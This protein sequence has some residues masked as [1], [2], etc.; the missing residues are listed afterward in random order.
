MLGIDEAITHFDVDIIIHINTALNTLTQIGVGPSVGFTISDK[1]S[2]WEDF[3]GDDKL[4]SSVK[5]YVYIKVKLVF[6]PPPNSWVSETMKKNADELE[7][8]LNALV[9]V[10]VEEN[11]NVEL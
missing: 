3:I 4:L 9:D 5:T 8:R 1:D 11:Q 6:D 7:W 2:T 10:N